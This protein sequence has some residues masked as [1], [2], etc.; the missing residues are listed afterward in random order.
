ML[1]ALMMATQTPSDDVLEI[2]GESG[3]GKG[4][5]V[6]FL[7]GDEE[8]RSEEGLPQ[9]AK[10]LANR[11]GFTCTVVF[12]LNARGEIDPNVRNHQPGIEA[13]DR[14]DL[15][16]MLLRFREWPDAQMK[17]FV[18]YYRSGKPI[19]A[20]RTSTHAFAYPP[21]SQSPY[22]DF[23]WQS[24][25]WP[26]GFGKQVL[27]E[28]WLS[29][30]GNHGSQATRGVAEQNAA[31][32]P[33]LRGVEDVF[34]PSDVYEVVPPKDATV[35]MRGL[36]LD[37]MDPK[38]GTAGGK[39]MTALGVEQAVND[40][41]MPIVWIRKREN[42]AGKV[43]TVLT[44]TMGAATDLESEGLRRLLVN[45]VY[46]LSGLPVPTRANVNLVGEYRPSPF[47]FDGFRKS[48]K[49]RNLR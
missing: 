49:P 9:L 26:G 46:W 41:A 23:G 28:N 19:L 32:H 6:V 18:D 33:L 30:W 8:Y 35:L 16:V 43:N 27:G 10:I 4:R 47:G 22:R 20:L 17:H 2:V 11:H 45:G 34:G 36:V 24:K 39:K 44:C 25:A 14:A 7:A 15:C 5:R 37:G 21:D 13:L 38:S 42:E 29:H 3:P 12:S 31:D 40:P 1:L 48:V